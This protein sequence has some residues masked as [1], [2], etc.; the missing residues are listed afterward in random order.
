MLYQ[1]CHRFEHNNSD[2]H[3]Y[4]TSYYRAMEYVNIVYEIH[5]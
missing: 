4:Q 2:K 5:T 3:Y 1:N